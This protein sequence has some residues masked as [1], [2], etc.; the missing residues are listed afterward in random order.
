M[1]WGVFYMAIRRSREIITADILKI[2]IGGVSKTKIVSRT[3]M[4][5]ETAGSY[6]KKLVNIGLLQIMNGDRTIYKTTQKGLDL[7][8]NLQ[9]IQKETMLCL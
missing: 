3:N 5:S 7:L 8:K 4:N 9:H 6:L 2:C 1:G